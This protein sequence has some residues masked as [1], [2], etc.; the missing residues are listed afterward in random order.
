MAYCRVR[1]RH[2]LRD[3]VPKVI[4]NEMNGRLV[5]F[6]GEDRFAQTAL[7]VLNDPAAQ[8]P[9]SSGQVDVQKYG[10]EYGLGRL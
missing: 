9:C 3:A 4:R 8:R 5:D 2:S 6:F 10:R 1:L 7:Y